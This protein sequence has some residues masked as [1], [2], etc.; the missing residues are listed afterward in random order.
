MRKGNAP[1]RQISPDVIYQSQ[2]V[3]KLINMIMWEGK[4]N[5]ARDIVYKSFDYIADKTKKPPLEVFI[6]AIDNISPLLELKVRRIAGSNYQVPSEVREDRKKTLALR[7]LIT[8]ARERNEKTM[9]IR[10]AEEIIAA[11]N[12]TGGAV[13]KREDTQKMA[14]ANKAYAHLRF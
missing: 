4:K 12:G 6:K 1:K 13:K 2:D 3:N 14:E 5:L 11:S 10:L 7:W 9:T 8:Y